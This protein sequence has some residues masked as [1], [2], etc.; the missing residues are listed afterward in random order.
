M[1]FVLVNGKLQSKRCIR[2]EAYIFYYIEKEN[3]I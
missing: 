1:I 3:F 2:S